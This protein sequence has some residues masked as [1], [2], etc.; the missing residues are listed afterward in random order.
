[1]SYNPEDYQEVYDAPILVPR[2]IFCWNKKT[3]VLCPQFDNEYSVDC[4]KGFSITKTAN[5]NYVK[6]QECLDLPV[7]I[8]LD[9]K[10]ENH[11]K[12]ITP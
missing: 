10:N 4:H 9:N 6:D 2:D 11:E 1:M 7:A 8:T 5:G 12:E 3:H